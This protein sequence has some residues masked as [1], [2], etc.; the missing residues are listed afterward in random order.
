MPSYNHLDQGSQTQSELC[1][2]TSMYLEKQAKWLKVFFKIFIFLMYFSQASCLI[3]LTKTVKYPNKCPLWFI[4]VRLKICHPFITLKIIALGFKRYN[5]IIDKISSI[6]TGVIGIL[7][8][9]RKNCK[10]QIVISVFVNKWAI[11]QSCG[12][13]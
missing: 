4:F 3:P 9:K 13:P 8:S 6:I 5:Y 10:L 7:A 11:V 2:K 1:V 12:H